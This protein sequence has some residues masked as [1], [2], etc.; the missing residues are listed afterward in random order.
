VLI[1][2]AG[3]TAIAGIQTRLQSLG[4]VQLVDAAISHKDV[5]VV[6]AS[7]EEAALAKSAAAL[8]AIS[9]DVHYLRKSHRMHSL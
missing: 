1:S 5:P 2:N 8:E 7:G 4:A 3:P 6:I 9:S